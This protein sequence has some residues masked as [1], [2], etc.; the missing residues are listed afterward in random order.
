MG[1]ELMRLYG[2]RLFRKE[3]QR[4]IADRR[5][6][7]DAVVYSVNS[8]NRFC[9]VKIQGSD[10]QIKAY[11]PENWESTPQYLKPGNAV[12]I[13]H[14]GG[15]KGRIEVAGHGFLVPTA[16]P[17]GSTTPA[18]GTP[19]DSVLTGCS[20]SA[21]DPVSMSVTVAPGTFRI[22]GITYALSG[23][24]MDRSDIVMDRI[25]LLMDSVGDSVTFDAASATYFRYDSIVVG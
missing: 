16:V 25:D 10:T 2:G 17:G 13:T 5:E 21:T 9:M 18:P 20:L 23:M 15:N 24:L 7:R 8:A 4:Q 3:V 14:P 19:G 6:M 22:D 11:Y 12:R 1:G